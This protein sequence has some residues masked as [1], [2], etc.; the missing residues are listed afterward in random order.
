MAALTDVDRA[1]TARRLRINPD[2]T[3]IA[4][5]DFGFTLLGWRF[6]GT[7]AQPAATEEGG[8]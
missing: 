6:V 8:R 7:T 3:Y 2:K 5:F 4:D 1:V